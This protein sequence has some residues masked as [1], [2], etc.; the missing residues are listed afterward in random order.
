MPND[1]SGELSSKPTSP[2]CDWANF[3][4]FG[5]Q[6]PFWPS[7]Y[8]IEDMFVDCLLDRS[9]KLPLKCGHDSLM[10]DAAR[11]F[12]RGFTPYALAHYAE[13]RIALDWNEDD[14]VALAIEV[15]EHMASNRLLPLRTMARM[16][17]L[18]SNL[19]RH[20]AD[21]T[22]FDGEVIEWHPHIRRDN[23]KW[24]VFDG[25]YEVETESPNETFIRTLDYIEYVKHLPA[26]LDLYP[27]KRD[28]TS[29]LRVGYA[30]FGN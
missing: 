21:L 5:W 15:A 16:K 12:V 7:D 20:H 2:R 1:R 22:E 28:L 4:Q 19:Y 3:M 9:S 14:Y 10:I 18:R 23:V 13:R 25:S 17:A 27:L 29:Y 30:V 8:I 6:S 24:H 26:Y 11:M